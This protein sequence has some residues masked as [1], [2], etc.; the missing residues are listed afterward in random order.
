MMWINNKAVKTAGRK[1]SE[2]EPSELS[3]KIRNIFTVVGI[4]L[5]GIGMLGMLLECVSEDLKVFYTY[6]LSLAGIILVGFMMI[7]ICR[8]PEAVKLHILLVLS[9]IISFI[10]VVVI[11][12][13]V[14]VLK[15]SNSL[16]IMKIK[17]SA[18]VEFKRWCKENGI[19]LLSS[20]AF[21]LYIKYLESVLNEVYN[22]KS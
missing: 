20:S 5:V 18:F 2:K 21:N 13:K 22:V 10:E 15:V 1:H 16:K 9:L 6:Y 3:L 14:A 4:V 7:V 19:K 12:L 8:D 11:K 17:I